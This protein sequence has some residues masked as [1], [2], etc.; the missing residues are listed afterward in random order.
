MMIVFDLCN[1]FTDYPRTSLCDNDEVIEMS[2]TSNTQ[3]NN[4]KNTHTESL[5]WPS[6][7]SRLH[8]LH[9][10]DE[11]EDEEFDLYN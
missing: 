6:A 3:H 7:Q 2:T 11:H 4:K 8:K 10:S 9:E 1:V 5:R